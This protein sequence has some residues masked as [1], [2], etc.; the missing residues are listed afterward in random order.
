MRQ[1]RL[2]LFLITVC[3]ITTSLENLKAQR[4]VNDENKT[5]Q[6]Q[7]E[8]LWV[9]WDGHTPGWFYWLYELFHDE[10]YRD[11]DRR[12][13]L[14]LFPAVYFAQVTKEKSEKQKAYID[15]IAQDKALVLA[16]L[17][18][19]YAYSMIEND[20]TAAQNRVNEVLN[21]A[22]EVGVFTEMITE[23]TNEYTRIEGRI[24]AIRH[25]DLSNADRQS[26]YQTEIESLK[27]LSVVGNKMIIAF[28]S[29][30]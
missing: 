25:S 30:R 13:F 26:G 24:T 18:V 10:A 21:K 9:E 6:L 27:K 16:D 14:Q 15:A 22:H 3:L 1:N 19:D 7:R 8:V 23:M 12:N 29:I 11:K 17:K 4:I 20:L 5:H 2:L 28:K